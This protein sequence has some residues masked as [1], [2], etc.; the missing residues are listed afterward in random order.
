[1]L[2]GI[3][4]LYRL[5]FAETIIYMLQATEYRIGSYLK[6]LWR[7]NDFRRVTYRKEL[8]R[9]RR[10]QVLLIALK[11]GMLAQITISLI[12]GVWAIKRHNHSG[13]FAIDLFAAT[14][15]VWS[16][17]IVLPLILAKWTFVNPYNFFIVRAATKVFRNHPAI[18]NAVAGSY[19][20]TTMKEI[21]LSVT[22]QGKKVA[23]TP[24]NKNVAI[25]HA[26][27]AKS[28]SGDEEILIIEYGEGAPGD[29]PGFIKY[30]YPNIGVITGLAP[31]HLDKYKTLKHAGEDIFSL[32][33]YLGGKNIYINDESQAARTFIKKGQIY[34]HTEA[35]G[36]KISN[37]KSSIE[38]VSFVLKK[39]SKS[40]RL[41][42]SLLGIHQVGPLACAA[43][44]ADRLGLTK[45]QI[46]K[47]V[48]KI[49]PFE[50]RMQPRQAAGA[51]IIDDTYN[52]NIEGVLAGLKLLKD[53]PAKRKIYV[54]PG[55]VDQ[56][57]ES[58]KVHHQL[59]KAIA[60]ASP[61][62]VI[63]MRHSVTDDIIEGIK[64]GN[65][66]GELIIEE[67]PLN[68][69]THLDQFLAAGDLILLQND[70][71]DNYN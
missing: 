17:L 61:D 52:G 23:A 11:A 13:F 46:E 25:S 63:L 50:H 36:W 19:R 71:P 4:Y 37:I 53:L 33:D 8:V 3:I 60:E 9:T 15:L 14:P 10:S 21:L 69:Y 6:W 29:V 35:A 62:M 54:T 41:T 66:N 7:V 16:H 67:D 51:W 32:A 22:S 38:G 24:A 27:F 70:W 18:K 5:K 28:L 55:L 44:I 65:F 1:M 34:N 26:Q 40:F 49:E 48:A 30:T 45:E 58:S 20:K 39:D 57:N 68:F 47:G 42:S 31:A 2:K 43:A 56:G 64:A 12:W 59:G